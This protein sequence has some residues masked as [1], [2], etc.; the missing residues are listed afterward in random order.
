[1]D[2]A[3]LAA[4]DGNAQADLRDA[5][6]R[7]RAWLRR[8]SAVI[9]AHAEEY[10]LHPDDIPELINLSSSAQIQ[11]LLFGGFQA[12]KAVERKPLKAEA[13][14][15]AVAQM[16]KPSVDIVRLPVAYMP[17]FSRACPEL[18]RGALPASRLCLLVCEVQCDPELVSKTSAVRLD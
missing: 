9:G 5:E 11:T 13:A 3:H 15:G 16:V 1:M 7:F 4:Q 14:K 2:G 10:G 6:L 8:H 12:A 18:P 17:C